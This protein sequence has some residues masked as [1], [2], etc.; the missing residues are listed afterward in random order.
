[1]WYN[2]GIRSEQFMLLD[3]YKGF[4]FQLTVK[5]SKILDISMQKIQSIEFGEK[6]PQMKIFRNTM[7]YPEILRK[8]D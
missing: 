5:Y 7:N 8:T 4:V 6:N 1:M 2:K 3:I